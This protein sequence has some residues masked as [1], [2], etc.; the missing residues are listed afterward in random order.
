MM[1]TTYPFSMFGDSSLAMDL[2]PLGVVSKAM[3]S[4]S[5]WKLRYSANPDRCRPAELQSMSKSS[6]SSPFDEY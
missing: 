2:Q 1:L 3:D 4:G 5:V 6:S